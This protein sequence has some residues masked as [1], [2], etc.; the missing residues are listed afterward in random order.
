MLYNKYKNGGYMNKFIARDIYLQQLIGFKDK[1]LIKIITGIRRCG[2]STLFELFQNYLLKNGIN[3]KQIQSINL[4]DANNRDLTDWKVL[5]DH[6]QS[7]LVSRKKNYVFIDEIQNVVDFQKAADSLFIKKNV[8]LYLTGSNSHILSGHWATLLSGRYVEIHMF[9][10]SFKE[11]TSTLT[12]K[13][14]MA[15]KFQNYLKNSSFP[16]ALQFNGDRNQINNYL[17]GIYNTIVLKDVVERKNI[18]DVGRLERIIRFMSDNIGSLISLKRISDAISSDIT[19]GKE[20]KIYPQTIENYLDALIDGYVFYKASRYDIKGKQHLRINDKYY[21]VDIGLRY[22]LLG[23]Q[24]TDVGHILENV[25]YLELLRRGYEVYI[26]K[27]GIAEVDFVAR[28][29]GNIEYYQVAQSVLD[30]NTLAREIKPLNDIRDHNP[31]IL[32]SMDYLGSSQNGIK[33]I[34]VL[35]W[36]LDLSIGTA[37]KS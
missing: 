15:K 7:R 24:N 29:N 36:L 6:I 23:D 5:H 3:K 26:G 17:R 35:D 25:V 27:V 32:L 31:K 28:K 33:Q 21:L 22:L 18:S 9:P 14:D 30:P 12:D 2:K 13:T 16:Y 37:Y 19:A 10:L 34:N 20:K 11:Y 1:Q 8:D 4:E